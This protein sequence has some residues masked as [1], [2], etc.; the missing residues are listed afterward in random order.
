M[1]FERIS[2]ERSKEI[3]DQGET[4][5]V[6]IRDTDSFETGHIKNAIQLDNSIVGKFVQTADKSKPLL[7]YCY[8][9]N[10]SQGAADFFAQQGFQLVY[11]MD[12]GFEEWRMKY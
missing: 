1:S 6:D 5:V 3:I 9:G 4:I 12:G 7:I 10:S 2:I 8:H 11:S